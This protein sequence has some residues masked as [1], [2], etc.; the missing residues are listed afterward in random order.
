MSQ[1][2]GLDLIKKIRQKD[3]YYKIKAIVISATVKDGIIKQNDIFFNLKIDKFLE[4]PI[5]LDNLKKE[6]EIDLINYL[7][8][9]LIN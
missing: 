1:M 5:E 9:F 6:R 2:S 4:K 7:I 8:I 3:Q